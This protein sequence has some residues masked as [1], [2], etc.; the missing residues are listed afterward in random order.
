MENFVFLWLTSSCLCRHCWFW[1]AQSAHQPFTISGQAGSV[2]EPDKHPYSWRATIMR[3]VIPCDTKL[4][5]PVSALVQ[6]RVTLHLGS[7]P[8]RTATKQKALDCACFGPISSTVPAY[9]P[10]PAVMGGS[11]RPKRDHSSFPCGMVSSDMC[12]G[13]VSELTIPQ[14]R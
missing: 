6:S 3:M 2:M 11:R 7:L 13:H 1:S 14:R 4:K 5:A 9:P 8:L 10:S 12:G